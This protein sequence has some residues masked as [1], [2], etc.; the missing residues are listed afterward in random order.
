MKP[1]E[2]ELRATEYKD[3]ETGRAV[4][5]VF[6]VGQTGSH[7][8]FTST[9]Y[10][11]QSRLI[12]GAQVDGSNQLV[13]ID[14]KKGVMHQVTDLGEMR[15]QSYCVCT[16][17]DIAV[18]I[19]GQT[20]KKI[21]LDSGKVTQ[22]FEI[23]DRWRIATPT[24]DAKGTRIAFSVSEKIEGFTAADKIYST[25][26]E[27]FFFRPRSMVVTVDLDTGKPGV[28][29]GETEWISHVL[30]NPV[31]PDT[32]VFCHEGGSSSQHR[33]WVVDAR[34]LRK[35]Q[36]RL[37]YR[38]A[39]E[40]FLVHE[41]FL[42]DGT[43]GVQYSVYPKGDAEISGHERTTSTLM[44]LNMDGLVVS[45]YRLPGNRSGHVQS[46]S[47]NTCIVA[48]GFFPKKVLPGKDPE[49]DDYRKYMAL[50]HPEG[51]GIRVEKLC[52]HD[53]SGKTQL[54][55]PHPIFSP[56]DKSALFSS[57]AGG[58]NSAFVVEI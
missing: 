11:S 14:L 31:D 8:Y 5:R 43:L 22:I 51:G 46:N 17:R 12:L 21:D 47:D 56:D 16:E 13:R 41:Y 7:A 23:S 48:D 49:Y 55:H 3:R 15:L 34:P 10:D 32:I 27:S 40:D 4:T 2:K 19:D 28:A 18:V 24:I 9:S 45:N 33:L 50:N 29:W 36:A 26:Q 58:T 44:F 42:R 54:S 25:M 38:E 20:L 53:T 37:L 39:Y 1:V 6:P 52:L 35:K 57:D 30:I